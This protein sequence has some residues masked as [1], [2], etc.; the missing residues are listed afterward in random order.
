[1]KLD[2]PP[3]ERAKC[4]ENAQILDMLALNVFV[5]V[6]LEGREELLE[7]LR[8][9]FDELA[10]EPTFL[11]AWVHTS[12]EEPDSVANRHLAFFRLVVPTGPTMHSRGAALAVKRLIPPLWYDSF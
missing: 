7:A 1:M 3:F 4:F 8:A 6:K 11:D 5:R 10:K 9:L 12:M 2:Q